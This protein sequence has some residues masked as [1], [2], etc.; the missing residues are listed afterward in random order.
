MSDTLP[1][2][3]SFLNLLDARI[4]AKNVLQHPFYQ[5][6]SQGTL[7]LEALQD[8]A[9]QYYRHVN[10]F[11]TYLSAVHS[12][13]SDPAVR[14]S[15]LQNLVDEEAGTPNHPELWIQFAGGIGVNSETV[16]NAVAQPETTALVDTFQDICRNRT[17]AE[18]IA[19]LYAY[20]SQIPEV[21][22][23]KIAGLKT[24]YG[25]QD[26]ETLRYFAVHVEAD[27][28]HRADER[29]MLGNL[30]NS[31]NEADVMKSADRALDSVWNLLSGIC[32][33]HNIACN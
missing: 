26:E 14:R 2:N 15:L 12:N 11:P 4:A 27:E 6:W 22:L 31:A 13:S 23:S 19:A 24:H 16:R 20:E 1:V 10:A 33:R 29:S 30:V 28:V 5:A 17:C 3:S 7:S 9:S 8:Y 25:I 18:G 21:A 32:A